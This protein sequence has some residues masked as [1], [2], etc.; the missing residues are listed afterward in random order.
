[1]KA[2]IGLEREDRHVFRDDTMTNRMEPE[3][4]GERLPVDTHIFREVLDRALLESLQLYVRELTRSSLMRWEEWAQRLVRHNDPF[5]VLLH[6][7]VTPRV[8]EALGHPVKRSYCFLAAYGERATLPR[9]RD[10][11]QCKYTLDLCIEDRGAGAWPLQIDGR[12]IA[13]SPN[14]A[15]L[16]PGCELEHHRDEKPE[17]KISH[18]AFF[19]FVDVDFEGPLD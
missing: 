19:H 6:E 5:V 2:L 16:Y 11:P 15:L 18:L 1:M 17:G 12:Q 8:A 4:R 7:R 3:R 9:H 10:R 13:L 14:E